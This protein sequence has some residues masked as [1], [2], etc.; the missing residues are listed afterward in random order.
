MARSATSHGVPGRRWRLI[1]SVLGRLPNVSMSRA[2]GRLADVRIPRYAR[3]LVLGTF[4]RLVGAR[5]EEA[6]KPFDAYE[7][8][9]AFF[10][11][12]LRHGLRT[13]PEDAAALSSPVDGIIGQLGRISEGRLLQA[14]G[15]DYSVAELLAGAGDAASFVDGG[16]ITIYLS[17]RHYHRIH[18]PAVGRIRRAVH[19]PGTLLPVNAAAV[20]HVPKLFVRNERVV[21]M[22][23]TDRGSLALVAVGAYNVGRISTA[24]DPEWRPPPGVASGHVSRSRVPEARSY[25]PPLPVTVGEEVMAFHLGSTVIVLFEPHGWTLRKDLVP[26]VEVRVGERLDSPA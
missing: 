4:S 19:V 26:G 16:Y 22:I 23:D 7:T 10:V 11:R 1:L 14:K 24:F 15:H 8:L 2:F 18:T 13:W 3:P 25:D 5:P 17:P 20:A 6:E 21:C 12:R 9:N